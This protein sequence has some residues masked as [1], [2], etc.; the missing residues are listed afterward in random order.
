MLGAYALAV[1]WCLFLNLCVKVL[2]E[3]S[4]MALNR[5]DQNRSPGPACNAELLLA[6]WK[7]G[8]SCFSLP[9]DGKPRSPEA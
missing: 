7:A 2:K 9:S 8:A 4:L 6:A 5:Y 3:K 1:Y